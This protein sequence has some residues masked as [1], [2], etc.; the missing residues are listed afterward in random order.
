MQM[1][2]LSSAIFG[3]TSGFSPKIFI[4]KKKGGFDVVVRRKESREKFINI[5][6]SR[7]KRNGWGRWDSNF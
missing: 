1:N 3:N 6:N 7:K 2:A 5:I 4:S